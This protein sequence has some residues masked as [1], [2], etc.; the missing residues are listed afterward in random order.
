MKVLVLT[1]F[2]L[3]ISVKEGKVFEKCELAALLKQHGLDQYHGIS[4][5]DWICTAYHESKY[6]SSAVGPPNTDGSQDYGVFQINSRY[7]CDN[8]QGETANGCR[9]SCSAFTDDNITDDIECA[10]TV[11]RDPQGMDAWVAWKNHCKG[12]DLSEWTI[13]CSL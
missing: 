4:L 12:K 7:W 2:C 6:E 9:I 10:K 13:G 3:L 8:Q 1:L 5:A 11:V